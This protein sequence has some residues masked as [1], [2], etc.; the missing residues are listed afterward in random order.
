MQIS[1]LARAI[2]FA[3]H[4]SGDFFKAKPEV[5]ETYK[6]TPEQSKSLSKLN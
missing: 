2:D 1:K 3:L 4:I 6:L 5:E